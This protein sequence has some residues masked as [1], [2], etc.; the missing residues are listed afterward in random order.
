[1]GEA[2]FNDD[3]RVYKDSR[4]IYARIAY[5]TWFRHDARW[6][7]KDED[8]F[9]SEILGHDDENTQ[10]HYK[11]FKLHNFSRTWTPEGETKTLACRRYRISMT[12][13]PDSRAVTRRCECM[14]N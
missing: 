7:D 9:F 14:K 12:R 3:R 5:E 2:V 11:Q 10:L 1:M 8:V 4:A 6:A 13:C